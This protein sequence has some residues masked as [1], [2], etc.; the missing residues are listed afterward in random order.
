MATR[1][2]VEWCGVV[3]GVWCGVV[4]VVWCGVVWCETVVMQYM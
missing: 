1:A 2:D 4:C 3:C